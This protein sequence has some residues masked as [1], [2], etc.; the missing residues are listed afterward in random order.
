MPYAPSRGARLHYE[1]TGRGR[2]V[3]FSHEF[4][5]DRRTWEQQVRFLGRQYRCIT[6]DARGYP[7]SDVPED[8]ALYGYED[9][10]DDIAAVLDAVGEP[11]AHVLGLSMGAYASLVFAIRHPGRATS[12]VLSGIGSGALETGREAFVA[13]TTQVAAVYRDEGSEAAAALLAQGPTRL[14]LADKDPRGWAE[15]MRYLEAHSALGCALTMERFQLL[16]PGF[17]SMEPALRALGVPAL[18]LC[19]DE[20]E[21]CIEPSLYLKRTLPNAGL[22][23]LPRSGHPLNLEEPAAFNQA[24]L[25]FLGMVERGQAHARGTDGRRRPG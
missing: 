22:Q 6:V 2:P 16:R 17:R 9:S 1:V 11:T 20:D 23:M 5:A 4:G 19:G 25:D 3:I 7:P 18:I 10:A 14:Q 8:P 24:V 21:P 12:L 13:F 15:T